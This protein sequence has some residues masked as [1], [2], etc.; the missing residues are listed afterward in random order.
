MNMGSLKIREMA[1]MNIGLLAMLAWRIV[2]DPHS[3]LLE[4]IVPKY[5]NRKG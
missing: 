5:K 3:I 1:T 4:V 2:S